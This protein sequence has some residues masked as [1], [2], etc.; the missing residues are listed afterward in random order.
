MV[1]L[2][3]DLRTSGNFN[4][5]L[6]WQSNIVCTSGSLKGDHRLLTPSFRPCLAFL[7]CGSLSYMTIG[8]EVTV[9]GNV[10][11]GVKK[12]SRQ[13]FPDGPVVKNLPANAGDTSL[14]PGQ[15]RLHML[16]YN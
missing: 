1:G 3:L 15:G 9:F 5:L 6:T 10:N 2:G 11:F 13:D 7:P 8:T 12:K 4:A 14:I 16:Q